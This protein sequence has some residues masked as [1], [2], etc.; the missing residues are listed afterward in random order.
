M[1]RIK[2]TLAAAFGMIVALAALGLFAS[3]GLVL[4]GALVSIGAVAAL[5]LWIQTRFAPKPEFNPA[6][7]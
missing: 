6:A 4:F 1:N 2:S 7:A 3:V 5:G